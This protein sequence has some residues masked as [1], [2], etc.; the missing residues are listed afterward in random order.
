VHHAS[1]TAFFASGFG[2]KLI[3][4]IP[5]VDLVIVTAA[6]TEE[7]HQHPEQWKEIMA[8][9]PDYVLPAMAAQVV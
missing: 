3:Y 9:I 6:S 8:L 2:G 5:G 1:L 4:V 7:A